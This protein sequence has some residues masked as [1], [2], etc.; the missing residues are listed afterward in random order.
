MAEGLTDLQLAFVREYLIDLNATAAAK[1]AGYSEDSA[2]SIGSE[3]LTKPDIQDAIAAAMSERAK[4]TEIT[5]DKVIKELAAIGFSNARSV[6]KWGPGGVEPIESENLSDIDSAC[7]SEVSETRTKEGGSIKV[8]LYDKVAALEKLGRHLG[9]WDK[10]QKAP[11]THL[12]FGEV[13]DAELRAKIEQIKTK[14]G[15]GKSE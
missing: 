15:N 5:A 8:K 10:E 3:N 13:L 11:E 12:H 4:R 9:L 1:R 14:Q 7:V 2:R 6:V